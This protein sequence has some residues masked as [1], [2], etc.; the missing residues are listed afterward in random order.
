MTYDEQMQ[1]A[2]R[3]WLDTTYHAEQLCYFPADGGPFRRINAQV[4]ES[5]RW[6]LLDDGAT[7]QYV[8]ELRLLVSRDPA[9]LD[10]EGNLIG[11]ID[12]PQIEDAVQRDQAI[13]PSQ[14]YYVFRGDKTS[15]DRYKW[16]LTFERRRRDTQG[17]VQ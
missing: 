16:R 7:L 17:G 3:Q 13:D 4:D 14:D 15:V 5:G 10:A 6:D 1:I 2:R 9:T 12:D 8:E 11:G